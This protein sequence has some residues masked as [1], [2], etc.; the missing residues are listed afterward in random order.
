MASTV[1][2]GTALGRTSSVD[3]EA[4]MRVLVPDEL[5]AWPNRVSAAP[6]TPLRDMLLKVVRRTEGEVEEEQDKGGGLGRKLSC[7]KKNLEK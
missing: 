5:E 4:A 7:F 2:L 3:A 1:M 6:A